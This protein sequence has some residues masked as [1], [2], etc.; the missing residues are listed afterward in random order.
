[1]KTRNDAL[2]VAALYSFPLLTVVAYLSGGGGALFLIEDGEREMM[3]LCRT[4]YSF[5]LIVYS[6]ALRRIGSL[7]AGLGGGEG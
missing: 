1:M 4:W 5:S 3:N 6:S 2:T 7:L